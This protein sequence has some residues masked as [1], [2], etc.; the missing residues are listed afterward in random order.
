MRAVALAAAVLLALAGCR[1]NFFDPTPG[2]TPGEA[3]RVDL[4]A[5]NIRVPPGNENAV[6]IGFRPKDTAVHLRVDR[7][8]TAGRLIACPLGG[9]DEALPPES[10]CLPD[11]PDGV[12]EGLTLTG[13]GAVAL[14]RE[15]DPI[16]IGMRI[17]YEEA[18]RDLELRLPVI[19]RP[20]GAAACK[21]N[22]CNPIF[23]LVPVR[24]GTFTATA[25]WTGGTGRLEVL[26]GRVLA[27]AFSSTG[28]P[29]R[30]AGEKTGGPP[31]GVT[32]TLGSPSEYALAFH[33]ASAGD[34]TD[35][36]LR[37]TWP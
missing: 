12:R 7:S 20:A 37:A 17:E 21:D 31:L 26:E 30:I 11:L 5:Q 18:G 36:E 35:I 3:T 28:I 6:R 29:Y 34:L 15:G 8:S 22:A 24:G 13:L 25:A 14:V 33:N 32:A 9:I 10:E 4:I 16:T 1:E 27:R 19:P 2:Q 23:E